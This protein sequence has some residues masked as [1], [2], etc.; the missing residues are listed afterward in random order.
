[1]TKLDDLTVAING[2]LSTQQTVN[3]GITNLV[4]LVQTENA[5]IDAALAALGG[6]SDDPAVQALIDAVTA[7]QG[8]LSTAANGLSDTATSISAENDKVVAALN[9]TPPEEP[10]P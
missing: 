10:T 3:D 8:N 9:P 5:N 4:T 1:M 7:A 6:S 2:L